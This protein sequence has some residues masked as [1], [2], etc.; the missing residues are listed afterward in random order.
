MRES[1]MKEAAEEAKR[2]LAP[3]TEVERDR[4][5]RLLTEALDKRFGSGAQRFLNSEEAAYY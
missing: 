3:A 1:Y 5:R 4:F 2:L